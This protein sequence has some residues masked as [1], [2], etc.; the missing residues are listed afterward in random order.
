MRF[1][2]IFQALTAKMT[3]ES[4]GARGRER[5]CARAFSSRVK[6][7]TC[8]QG[9]PFTEVGSRGVL[10]DA[11]LDKYNMHAIKSRCACDRPVTVFIAKHASSVRS[12]KTS[13]SNHP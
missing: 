6:P 2:Y 12:G 5:A 4:G 7:C 8:D 13:Q 1:L 9:N 3:S 10:V 11:S